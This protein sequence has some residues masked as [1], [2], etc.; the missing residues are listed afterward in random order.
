MDPAAVVSRR[1]SGEWLVVD[2]MSGNIDCRYH[3]FS[4]LVRLFGVVE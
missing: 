3:C 2:P 1:W 4:G